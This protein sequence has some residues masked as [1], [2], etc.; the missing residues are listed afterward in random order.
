MRGDASD[1]ASRSDEREGGP[2]RTRS[3][4]EVMWHISP[5]HAP[6]GPE[7]PCASGPTQPGRNKPTDKGPEARP[8]VATSLTRRVKGKLEV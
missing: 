2:P 6:P 5:E 4:D 3:L 7:A 8:S 1:W